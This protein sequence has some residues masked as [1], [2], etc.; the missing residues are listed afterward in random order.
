MTPWGQLH[1]LECAVGLQR[2]GWGGDALAGETWKVLGVSDS[3][4][5]GRIQC[6]NQEEGDW[7]VQA[8]RQPSHHRPQ[9][10]VP[11]SSENF[12]VF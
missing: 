4:K 3:G 5:K 12:W 1:A 2:V 10:A 7:Q 6:G 8:Q 11:L 9:P